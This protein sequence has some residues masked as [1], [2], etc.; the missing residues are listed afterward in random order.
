MDLKI[1]LIGDGKLPE[2]ATDQ[3]EYDVFIRDIEYDSEKDI[4]ICYLGFKTE[5]SDDYRGI[6]VP[7]SSLTKKSWIMQ[8]SP[9]TIDA[10]YRGEW[11]MRLR[12]IGKYVE[13]LPYSIGDRIGQIYFERKIQVT[14]IQV[15][16][17]SETNRGDGGFGHTGK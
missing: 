11:Q 10:D 6:L 1:Q 15:D 12:N 3:S 8:N 5:F 14:M 9:G 4:F 2:K 13:Y 17:L 16:E 7:R